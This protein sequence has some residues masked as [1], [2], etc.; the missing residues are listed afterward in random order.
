MQDGNE[1]L[2][3]PGGIMDLI[4]STCSSLT[5]RG[6]ENLQMSTSLYSLYSVFD[7]GSAR[8]EARICSIPLSLTEFGLVKS[9]RTTLHHL[10]VWRDH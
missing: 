7:C 1:I 8:S 2:R 3:D 10:C 6:V 5:A 4:A 9:V